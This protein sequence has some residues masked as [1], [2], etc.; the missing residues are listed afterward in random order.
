[1]GF[2]AK[3]NSITQKNNSLVCIGLDSE[4][5]KLPEHLEGSADPQFEFNKAIIDATADLVCA[6][7]PNMAFYEAEGLKGIEA[8]K[9]TMD[10]IPK[11]IPI[12]LDAKRGDID[13]TSRLYAQACFDYCHPT[14]GTPKDRL[15]YDN[16]LIA[17]GS[18][19]HAARS[20]R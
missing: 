19:P 16:D 12:I 7:K 20:E 15:D 18:L 13:N 3:L 10:Y 9:K 2:T 1:M 14:H 17:C 5:S 11:H 8:L 4:M 6:Y